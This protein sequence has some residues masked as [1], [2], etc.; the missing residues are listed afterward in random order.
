MAPFP[1]AGSE[2]LK[3]RLC[4]SGTVSALQRVGWTQPGWPWTWLSRADHSGL[5]AAPLPRPRGCTASALPSAGS[6]GLTSRPTFQILA[7]PSV[8]QGH[9]DASGLKQRHDAKAIQRE[10]ALEAARGA[11]LRPTTWRGRKKKCKLV[12]NLHLN[13]SWAEPLNPGGIPRKHSTSEDPDAALVTPPLPHPPSSSGAGSDPAHGRG[14]GAREPRRLQRVKP[15]G[16]RRWHSAAPP[17]ARR[18]VR[19]QQ[20]NEK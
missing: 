2:F 10:E 16:K 4:F 11:A 1:A 19:F 20:E 15:S 8:P 7:S 13:I 3:P 9:C 6:L 17:L 18:G 14:G 5:G 12:C